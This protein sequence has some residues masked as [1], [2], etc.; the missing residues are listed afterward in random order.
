MINQKANI[1]RGGTE[2][3][4][5]RPPE[6]LLS[7][8]AKKLCGVRKRPELRMMFLAQVRSKVIYEQQRAK[9]RGP[10]LAGVEGGYIS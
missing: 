2:L 6:K 4:R 10:S 7:S 8:L 5:M 9:R 3:G 1:S